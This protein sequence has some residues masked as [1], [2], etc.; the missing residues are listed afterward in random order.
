MRLA[1]L[2][3][4]DFPIGSK[5]NRLKELAEAGFPV[6]ETY[7]LEA[8]RESRLEAATKAAIGELLIRRFDGRA[9][10]VRST[11]S[12]EDRPLAAAPGVYDSFLNRRTAEEVIEAIEVCLAGLES[13]GP[14]AYRRMHGTSRTASMAVMLQEMIPC[15]VSGVL[16]TRNPVSESP[17]ML[18]ECA[19]GLGT[20]VV[21]GIGKS[22]RFEL[23]RAR[24]SGD[25]D[26]WRIGAKGLR[27]LLRTLGHRLESHYGTPQDVEWGIH[28]GRLHLFQSRDIV[29][30]RTRFPLWNERP[31]TPSS[32][33]AGEV[34]SP[35]FCVGRLIPWARYRADDAAHSSI[36]IL[37]ALPTAVEL[38]AVR[39]AAGVLVDHGT[40]LSHA[41]AM[42]RELGVPVLSVVDSLAGLMGR[43]LFVNAFDGWIAPIEEFGPADRKTGI[44]L[45]YRNLGA[46][47]IAGITLEDKYEAVV[48]DPI[49]QRKLRRLVED[50]AGF[51]TMIQRI[52]PFDDPARTYSGTSAR[53]QSMAEGYRVQFKRAVSLPDRPF[54]YDQEVHVAVSTEA[55]G[56][57]LLRR[58]AYV[59]FEAQQRRRTWAELDGLRIFVNEWPGAPQPYLSIESADPAELEK[60]LSRCGLALEQCRGY[61]GRD[62][63]DILG[64]KLDSLQFGSASEREKGISA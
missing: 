42:C 56:E 36:V 10:V 24:P 20:D 1:S 7:V 5:A 17:T 30:A 55:E 45:A 49:A 33:V 2:R 37:D 38:E 29:P 8:T 43:D 41:A 14:A 39:E 64:I 15:E 54:R 32:P 11:A 28:D 27:E 22:D 60:F 63:F 48:L 9:L 34:L 23:D 25:H 18:V 61:D 59:P 44:F 46:R 19:D 52:H 31:G 53:I 12:D 35:G 6:P 47:G 62:L 4:C 57:E 26:D 40:A 51:T 16:Y 3:E 50:E 21:A 13:A 58:L